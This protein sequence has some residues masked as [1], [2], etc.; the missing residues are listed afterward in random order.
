MHA[1]LRALPL[2][3]EADSPATSAARPSDKESDS[4]CLFVQ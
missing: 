2:M 1:A 3:A 4:I